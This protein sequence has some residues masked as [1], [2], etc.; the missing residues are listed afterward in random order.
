MKKIILTIALFCSL[1][2]IAQTEL[3]DTANFVKLDKTLYKSE[4]GKTVIR[5]YQNSFTA[6]CTGKEIDKAYSW[7]AYN[8]NYVGELTDN[9]GRQIQVFEND[10]CIAQFYRHSTRTLTVIYK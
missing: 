6:Q 3:I 7:A 2:A 4:D 1:Q 5:F 9:E 8:M 10:K